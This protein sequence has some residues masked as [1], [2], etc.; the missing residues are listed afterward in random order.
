MSA[1]EDE[2]DSPKYGQL[3]RIPDPLTEKNTRPLLVVSD[4]S[5]P[6]HGQQFIALARTTK[7]WLTDRDVVPITDDDLASG[8]LDVEVTY[9]TPWAPI[10]ASPSDVSVVEGRVESS[11]AAKSAGAA[12]R[13]IVG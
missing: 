3:V 10:T 13:Y 8:T 1:T 6:F 5:H 2:S 11:V 7:E 9:V 4:E 12:K